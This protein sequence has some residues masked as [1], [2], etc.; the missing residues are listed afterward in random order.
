ML[1]LG[2]LSAE[3]W[4]AKAKK[5]L[6]KLLKQRASWWLGFLSHCKVFSSKMSVKQKTCGNESF[7]QIP[8]K[9]IAFTTPLDVPIAAHVFFKK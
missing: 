8:K 5:S 2:G 4:K 1:S 7:L 9:G 6:I 3:P